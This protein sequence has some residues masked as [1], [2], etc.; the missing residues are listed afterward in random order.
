VKTGNQVF[1]EHPQEMGLL[2]PWLPATTMIHDFL[3]HA[4]SGDK[5]GTAT[6]L[7]YT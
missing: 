5:L 1:E 7:H 6:L 3:Y 2:D 4:F